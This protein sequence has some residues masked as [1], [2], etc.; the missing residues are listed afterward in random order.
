MADVPPTL[1]P[2]RFDAILCGLDGVLTATSK[3]HAI[4]WKQLF[5]QFLQH[6]SLAT[7]EAFQPFDVNQDYRRYLDGKLRYEG[8]RSFLESRGIELPYGSPEDS[9]RTESVCGLGN[10][11]ESLFL[12]VLAAGS[13][14]VFEGAVALVRYL[15]QQGMRAAVVSGSKN[16]EAVLASA[17]IADLFELWVDGRLAES[18]GLPGKPEPATLLKAAEMLD[19]DPQ[20]VVVVEDAIPGVRAGRRGGFGLVIGVDRQGGAEALRENGADLVV[21]DLA[22]LLP[23]KGGP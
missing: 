11:K 7:G 13:V 6:Q 20:R 17:G 10:R 2:E 15:R 21:G 23:A 12:E 16:C 18:L 9:P 22:E 4:C 1:D 3:I 19:V 8:V 14:G 5:D